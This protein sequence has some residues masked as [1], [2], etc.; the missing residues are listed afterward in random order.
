MQIIVNWNSSAANDNKIGAFGFNSHCQALN[1]KNRISIANQ[2]N[3][4]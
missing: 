3:L 1:K 4:Q 2:I